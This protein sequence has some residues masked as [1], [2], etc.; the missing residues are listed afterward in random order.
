[1]KIIWNGHSC[2]TVE[3][4]GSTVVVDPYSD[5]TVPGYAPLR[6]TADAVFCS[7]EHSDHNGREAVTLTGRDC[8]ISVQEIHTFHD[9]K[10]GSMRGENIIR[11]FSAEGM[12][13]AH[14]GDLGCEPEPEQLE[15]LKGLDA[16]LIPVGGFFTI[17]AEQAKSLVDKLEPRVVIPMH[18]SFPGHGYDVIETVDKFLKLCGNVV[19]YDT[20]IFELTADTPAQTAVLKK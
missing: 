14:L 16:V 13:V 1:M 4:D 15:Q 10:K 20:N 11:V 19:K 7:H 3:A 5:G 2:F 12:R 9:D 17:N 8:A 18:Y 6:L